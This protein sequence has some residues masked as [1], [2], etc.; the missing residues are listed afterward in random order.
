MQRTGYT[1]LPLHTGKAPRWLFKRMVKL[2][3]AITDAL[4]LEYT[5]DEFLK[6]I[7]NPYWFQAFSCVLGFDWHSSGTTTTTCGALKEALNQ[8]N[9]GIKIAGGKGSAS[10]KTPTQ[11]EKIAE[12]FSISTRKTKKLIYSSKMSA[13]IDNSLIQDDY[14]LYHHVFIL[15]EKGKWAV[16]QQGMNP[17]YSY[18]RRYHWLSTNMKSFVEEP[19]QAICCDKKTKNTLNMTAKQSREARK[20]S[21][22]LVKERNLLNY[23]KK[24]VQKTLIE[25]SGKRNIILNMPRTHLITNMNK[26]NLQTLKRAFEYQPKNYEELVAI[27]GIGPRIIRALALISELI[28]STPPSWE[29]PVKYSFAHGGKDGIPYPV[30]KMTMDESTQILGNAVKNAK[31]GNKDK[32]NALKRL[33]NL[34]K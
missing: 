18:A 4:L 9:F 11:I 26:I 24:P 34:Y 27:K 17:E 31:I 16:I 15:T 12:D 2:A 10:R 14:H 3:R 6:R 22:D 32:L 28:Y 13:K 21:V 25:F 29:D 8:E 33:S 20:I 19:Q 7:A 30:N 1:N 5:Q 23:F